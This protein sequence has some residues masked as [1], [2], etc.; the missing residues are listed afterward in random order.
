MDLESEDGITR[1]L[2]SENGTASTFFTVKEKR[3]VNK[4]TLEV[5]PFVSVENDVVKISYLN[6][7]LKNVEFTLENEDGIIYN[8]S[9]G[10]EFSISAGFDIRKLAKGDYAIKILNGDKK[11]SYAFNK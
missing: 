4:D 7:T 9:L 11:Y 5:K 3:F 10:N 1:L 6:H 8:K 2:L